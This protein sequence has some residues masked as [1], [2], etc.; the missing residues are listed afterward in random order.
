MV[1]ERNPAL[2]AQL[3]TRFGHVAALETVQTDAAAHNWPHEPFVVVANLPFARAEAILARLVRDPY[4]PGRLA[5]NACFAV[6]S[7]GT[8]TCARRSGERRS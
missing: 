2:T 8:I 1:V 4:L 7:H 6:N 5:R 3:R